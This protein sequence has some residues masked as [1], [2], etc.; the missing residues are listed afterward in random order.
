MQTELREVFPKEVRGQHRSVKRD[1]IA[2][3][4]QRAM[5]GSD[6]AVANE[7]LWM[8][9]DGAIIK[10]RQQ[11]RRA[12]PSAQAQDCP[13][14]RVDEHLHQVCRPVAVRASKKSPPLARVRGQFDFKPKLLDDGKGEVDALRISWRAR[15]SDNAHRIAIA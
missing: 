13:H 4:Q 9:L 6:I 7:D 15:W 12:I 11:S 10:Q 5:Q 3:G 1:E 8:R 14:L 2:P